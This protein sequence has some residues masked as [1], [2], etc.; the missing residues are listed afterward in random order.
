MTPLE[1]SY[2]S[3]KEYMIMGSTGVP[4]NLGKSELANYLS[5][6]K[7]EDPKMIKLEPKP[8]DK[9]GYG[10]HLI[11]ETPLKLANA[12]DKVK[13]HLGLAHVRL[14]IATTSNLGKIIFNNFQQIPGIH[15]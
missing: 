2:E 10:R 4:V 8:L 13:A 7:S 9:T 5:D 1:Q 12:V 3:T 15:L 14:A 6:H 11:L